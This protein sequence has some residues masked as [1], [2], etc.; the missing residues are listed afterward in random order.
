MPRTHW[1]RNIVWTEGMT[2]VFQYYMM[3][4]P[5]Q[6]LAFSEIKR[7]WSQHLEPSER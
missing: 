3:S 1:K 4:T 7:F 5:E 6:K 2:H